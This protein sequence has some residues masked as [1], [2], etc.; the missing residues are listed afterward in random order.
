MLQLGDMFKAQG[1]RDV[2]VDIHE[3][4]DAYLPFIHM[5][6]MQIDEE[7]LSRVDQDRA[8]DMMSLFARAAKESPKGVA[9]KYVQL[10][11]IR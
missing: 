4:Q 5:I 8:Q 2:R 7:I 3:L 1:M 11:T 10:T 6:F 9:W